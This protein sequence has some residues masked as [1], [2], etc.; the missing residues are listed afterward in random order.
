M[1]TQRH[2]LLRKTL[3]AVTIAASAMPLLAQAGLKR[4]DD[5]TLSGISG[6]S[7]LTLE[8]SMNV[9]AGSLGYFDDGNGIKLEGVKI[10]SASGKSAGAQEIASIDIGS[11]GSL[12]IA[13]TVN[14][15]RTEFSDLVLSD[16]PNVSGGGVFFDEGSAL[17]TLMIKPG[18]ALTTQGITV[19]SSYNLSAGRLGYRTNG[20]EVFLDDMS[21]NFNAP[22]WTLDTVGN[23]LDFKIPSFTGSFNIGAIRYSNNPLNHGVSN[24]VTT[25]Q[26]LPSYGALSGDFDLSGELKLQAGGRFGTQGMRLDGQVTINNADLSYIDDTHPLTL[27][28]ITGNLNLSDLRIDVAPDWNN[29]L[30]LAL[31]L[32]QLDGNINIAN[33]EIGD[34]GNSIGSIDLNFTL[35]DQTVSG[36]NYTNAVYIEG[37]GQADAGKQ[38][39]RLA[40]EWSLANADLS[41]TDDGNTVIFSGLKSWG[42]GDLTLNVTKAGTINNTQFFDGLRIGFENVKGGYSFDGLRV[43]DKNAPLQ[44]GTELLLA[45]GLYPSYDFTMNGQITLGAGGQSGAGLTINSDVHITKGHAALIADQNGN[46][47]WASDLDYD[48]H[49]RNMTVD[50]TST[51]LAIVKGEAWSTMDIGNLRV[52]DKLTGGSFGRV[53]VQTYETGSSMTISPGGAGNVCVG[54]TGTDSATCTAG[55]GIWEMRGQQGVTVSLKQVFAA[56]VDAT[57]RNRITWETN[58]QVDANGNA[59]NGTGEQL[60]IDNFH[61]SDGCDCN[62]DGVDDNTFGIQTELNVDVY[63]TKVVKKTT[64]PDSN[65][66]V[67]NVG[68]EKIMDPTAPAGYVYVTN[69]TTAQIA[70]RPL[71]F[72][73]KAHTQFKELDVGSVNLVHPTGGSQTMLYGVSIQNVDLTA[74]LTATPI[75]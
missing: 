22:N 21:L 17:G 67:G 57:K 4:L 68:D 27:Q 36:V 56:A 29:R 30:G 75:Q 74:N 23:V 48:M 2:F 26:P 65:G 54:A 33:V 59:I 61:T 25:G 15:S 71:G 45:L 47:I 62:G 12:D 72:A 11:D 3:L 55:G 34:A 8:M 46:G 14:D 16:N 28:G 10:G 64:G 60:V 35:A 32:G 58:R 31:T 38:G 6:Q 52:G 49:V 18:G 50:M 43:G 70:D 13:Y 41:Y 66:V 5:S 24:D 53:V 7:G 51:G 1:M 44:G 73:V 69:P 40:T 63:Q 19:S 9:S 39:L 20:N 37:G 42:Q